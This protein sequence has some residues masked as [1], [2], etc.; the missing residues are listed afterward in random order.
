MEMDRMVV[1]AIGLVAA[2]VPGSVP[3]TPPASAQRP[4]LSGRWRINVEK[5]E[6]G[7]EKVRA[8]AAGRRPEGAGSAR[9][10]SGAGRDGSR[11]GGSR[12][13]ATGDLRDSMRQLTEA[14]AEMTITQTEAEIAIVEKDGRLRLLHPDG[15]PRND[16]AGAAVKAYWDADRLVVRTKHADGP[17]R[18]ETFTLETQPR[19]L[20][21][22]SRVM[23]RALGGVT[24]WRV[25]EP[26]ASE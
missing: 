19:Q 3:Q 25:Y 4:A 14:P 15:Q 26:R 10:A 18:T 22:E 12:G 21:V 6:D 5:S 2:S 17:E 24:V 9:G 11:R 16:S 1:L 23:G 20:V 13:R 7:A 8:A